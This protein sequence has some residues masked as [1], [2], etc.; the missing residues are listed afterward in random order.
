LSFP[1]SSKACCAFRRWFF[2]PFG[3]S[4]HTCASVSAAVTTDW[5]GRVKKGF[6]QELPFLGRWLRSFFCHC[7]GALTL[8]RLLTIFELDY[9]S[10]MSCRVNRNIPILF[11][12]IFIRIRFDFSSSCP[13]PPL[14]HREFLCPFSALDSCLHL[15]PFFRAHVLPPPSPT[16][17]AFFNPHSL[18]QLDASIFFEKPL[19]H[20]LLSSCSALRPFSRSC[21]IFPFFS[22]RLLLQFL[23]SPLLFLPDDIRSETDRHLFFPLFFGFFFAPQDVCFCR[24]FKARGLFFSSFFPSHQ[25]PFF[26]PGPN[27]S[28]YLLPV[29]ADR[30]FPV[31]T[32]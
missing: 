26:F 17:P 23:V 4:C 32:C 7:A 11:R 20:V 14:W 10:G 19:P 30:L 16:V 2:L 22:F 27:P 1:L 9:E 31:V 12:W 24:L 29:D 21:F 5:G 6:L 25:G 18:S 13:P 3:Y 8:P 28:P 15:P